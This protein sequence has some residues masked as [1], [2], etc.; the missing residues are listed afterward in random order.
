MT[1]AAQQAIRHNK[2]NVDPSNHLH[3]SSDVYCVHWVVRSRNKAIL[4][5][6]HSSRMRQT[7]RVN[8][9]AIEI[10]VM[11]VPRPNSIAGVRVRTP[12]WLRLKI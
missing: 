6:T 11:I 1:N 12:G 2:C 4:R 10:V 9:T 7:N 5:V 8:F 3:I